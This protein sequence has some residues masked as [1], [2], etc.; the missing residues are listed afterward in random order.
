M[1]NTDKNNS[2]SDSYLLLIETARELFAK[3]GF[4][5]TTVRMISKQA[6][7]NVAAVNY[8]FRSKENLYFAQEVI[9]LQTSKKKKVCL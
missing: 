9:K 4:H 8:Y 3:H 7:V 5:N 1:N 6:N 2:I